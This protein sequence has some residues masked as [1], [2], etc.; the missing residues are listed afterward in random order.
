M[1]ALNFL[2]VANLQ[3]T[4]YNFELAYSLWLMQARREQSGIKADF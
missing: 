3:Y 4:A 1:A 2:P